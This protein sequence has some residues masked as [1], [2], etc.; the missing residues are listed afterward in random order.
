[1]T[2]SKEE[3]VKKKKDCLKNSQLEREQPKITTG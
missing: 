1:M 3:R 2:A